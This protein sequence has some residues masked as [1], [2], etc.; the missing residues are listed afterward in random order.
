[1]F[2]RNQLNNAFSELYHPNG[3]S[4]TYDKLNQLTEWRRGSLNTANTSITAPTRTQTWGLDAQGNWNTFA[5]N[6][7]TQT[8]GHNKQNQITS[9]TGATTPTFDPNG[10]MTGDE[11]GRTFV[12][13]AWNR[14][15]FMLGN[16]SRYD[17]LNRRIT[18]GEHFYYS[19]WQVIEEQTLFPFQPKAQYV[20]SP[21]Y[22]DAMICRDW[23]SNGDGT[24]D[25]RHYVGQ[26]ANWNV[27]II[28]STAAV[29]DE[30]YA[31]DPYGG[32]IVVLDAA[33]V[34]RP[35]GSLYVWAH[36][37][38]G[39]RFDASIGL[40][41]NRERWYS[42]SL[43]RFTSQDP[44]GFAGG[45]FNLY[46]Y[47]GNGPVNGVD[48]WGLAPVDPLVWADATS[49][50]RNA[51]PAVG[52]I[53]A[54]VAA[55]GGWMAVGGGA[56]AAG[57]AGVVVGAVGGDILYGWF[58]SDSAW[59]GWAQIGGTRRLPSGPVTQAE[60]DV[61][62]Q[63]VK[64]HP[65]WKSTQ[66][67]KT[68]DNA[69]ILRKNMAMTGKELQDLTPHHIV[70]STSN[71]GKWQEVRNILDKYEIDINC[72]MNGVPVGNTP[73]LAAKYGIRAHKGQGLHTNKA[74]EQ[75]LERFNMAIRA[76]K[77]WGEQ[78]R[79]VLGV[80]KELRRETF[81]GQFPKP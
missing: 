58:I 24:L 13:D 51:A 69:D 3:S 46:V 45:Y 39:L 57:G 77:T 71:W 19:G 81:F 11:T 2:K 26:D 62:W 12:Y 47:I 10:N 38:Q 31:P 53:S 4:G 8:R 48:P 44:I 1:M 68:D 80:L 35:G 60:R 52:Y 67:G 36:Y 18:N 50:G 49:A 15:V 41:E 9:I 32:S 75:I 30:R 27:T 59:E 20:W 34:V 7:V 43:G 29:V 54:W 72:D 73:E 33:W 56:V 42:P 17:A 63:N 25:Q 14:L 37:H 79:A 55:N 65:K 70:N 16:N 64:P 40:Y 28:V 76:Q 66:T 78:K 61:Y 6:G 5:T 23:D 22:I 21:V 74:S